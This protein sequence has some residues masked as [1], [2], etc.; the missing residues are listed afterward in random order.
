MGRG[1]RV[2]RPPAVEDKIL[3]DSHKGFDFPSCVL[4]IWQA[5]FFSFRAVRH[6]HRGR[7]VSELLVVVETVGFTSS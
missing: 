7:A 2:A 4:S 3:T 6:H 5:G 1:E